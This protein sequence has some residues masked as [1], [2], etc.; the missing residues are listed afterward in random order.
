M[1]AP[2]K[3]LYLLDGHALVY[4]YHFAFRD[5][6]LI[7]SKGVNTSAIVGFTRMLWDL[8]QTSKP[9][10]IAVIFDPSGPTFR[11]SPFPTMSAS[12]ERAFI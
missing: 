4:Q 11:S 2:E 7:N 9:S 12:P 10:H 8:L 3:V 5:R 6:P 1:A